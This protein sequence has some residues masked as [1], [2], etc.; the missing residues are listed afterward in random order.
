MPFKG[1]VLTVLFCL[2]GISSFLFLNPNSVYADPPNPRFIM[3]SGTDEYNG[4]VNRVRVAAVENNLSAQF[5]KILKESMK[6]PRLTSNI[7]ENCVSYVLGKDSSTKAAMANLLLVVFQRQADYTEDTQYECVRRKS[8]LRKKVQ[9]YVTQSYNKLLRNKLQGVCTDYTAFWCQLLTKLGLENRMVI[10]YQG[11]NF[12]GHMF[13]IYKDGDDWYIL[14]GTCPIDNFMKLG[15]SILQDKPVIDTDVANKYVISKETFGSINADTTFEDL[16]GLMS[17]D[18][19]T[20]SEFLGHINPHKIESYMSFESEPSPGA[21]GRLRLKIPEEF[22]LDTF[23]GISGGTFG[24]AVQIECSNRRKDISNY[25][26][27]I[28]P[29]VKRLLP[30]QFHDADKITEIDLSETNI[31]TIPEKCF[32]FNKSL[33]RVVFPKNFRVIEPG[34]FHMVDGRRLRFENFSPDVPLSV[35]TN[36]KEGDELVSNEFEKFKENPSKGIFGGTPAILRLGDDPL[37]NDKDQVDKLTETYEITEDNFTVIGIGMHTIDRT[38]ILRLKDLGVRLDKVR[39]HEDVVRI[40]DH[41]FWKDSYECLDFSQCSIH[42]INSSNFGLIVEC[43]VG[44]LILTKPII[45]SVKRPISKNPWLWCNSECGKI[46]VCP[47]NIG[48]F[49]Y[50]EKFF[51]GTITNDW[52]YCT[53]KSMEVIDEQN[54]TLNRYFND[55]IDIDRGQKIV[56]LK[57]NWDKIDWRMFAFEHYSTYGGLNRTKSL[58]IFINMLMYIF[59]EFRDAKILKFDG[60]FIFKD[61]KIEDFGPCVKEE[62]YFPH[63]FEVIDFSEVGDGNIES[64]KVRPWKFRK[65][66]KLKFRDVAQFKSLAQDTKSFF[67]GERPLNVLNI[68]CSDCIEFIER[69]ETEKFSS[70]IVEEFNV[71]EQEN[72]FLGIGLKE[73][74]L[75]MELFLVRQIPGLRERMSRIKLF[76]PSVHEEHRWNFNVLPAEPYDTIFMCDVL[77][78]RGLDDCRFLKNILRTDCKDMC[79]KPVYLVFDKNCKNLGPLFELIRTGIRNYYV[80]VAEDINAFREALVRQ[81]ISMRDF[82]RWCAIRDMKPGQFMDLKDAIR[83]GIIAR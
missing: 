76:A 42:G 2:M 79:H 19:M 62:F 63:N 55:F 83:S 72:G 22:G 18:C 52:G 39:I 69:D 44:E 31:D 47:Q 80:I 4:W 25:T 43:K 82:E 20:A 74:E 3:E 70:E 32:S 29:S 71:Q 13:N 35:L 10:K 48:M 81:K 77:D 24:T 58:E 59:P 68:S 61:S 57:G 41:T 40:E 1:K 73:P 66:C 46:R 45:I 26:V 50:P 34:A 30:E 6:V 5:P 49:C 12:V 51:Q 33:T 15:D 67:R 36:Y 16:F 17:Q 37:R 56:T 64:L 65:E 14:D 7:I 28:D 78:L 21:K 8:V 60:S 27:V 11:Q 75:D 53:I 23:P 54:E 38:Y 9:E